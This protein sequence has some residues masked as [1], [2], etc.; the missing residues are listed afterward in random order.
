M[1]YRSEVGRM[2]VAAAL[3]CVATVIGCSTTPAASPTPQPS[4]SEPVDSVAP[5]ASP[6]GVA[7]TS[8]EASPSSWPWDQE[9]SD[10]H[11]HDDV[12]ADDEGEPDG[13][14]LGDVIAAPP[15]D[16]PEADPSA[17][18]GWVDTCALVTDSE[19]GD[20]TGDGAETTHQELEDGDACGWIT[21]DD[22]V[23]MAIGAFTA[24]GAER[25]LSAEEAARGEAI[26]DLGDRAVWLENWPIEQS[27]TL[28]VEAGTIDLIIEMSARDASASASLRGGAVQFA[29]LALERLP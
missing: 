4:R 24:F 13:D 27:S 26:P 12:G 19:W 23:R 7:T 8:A 11:T 3:M 10:A 18:P 5:D 9:T 2:R 28:V 14:S 17:E 6:S 22:S 20:W 29:E 16:E 25:W 21:A 1:G 15:P